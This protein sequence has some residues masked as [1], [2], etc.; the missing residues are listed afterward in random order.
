MP[1]GN[2]R[3]NWDKVLEATH[4]AVREYSRRELAPLSRKVIHYL[5]RVEASGFFGND[6][7]YKTLWDEYCHRI[8]EEPHG[9]LE[10]AWD[11]EISRTID[12]VIEIIPR[13]VAVL[14][15]VFAAWEL[16]AD[17]DPEFIGSV[18]PDGLRQVLRGEL[19]EGAARRRIG[20]LGPW[21]R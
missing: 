13:H 8:Q 6:Y 21:G 17:D 19:N 1:R 5:Q 3:K 15:T 9:Q 2:W 16:D 4:K 20:H 18:W 10:R 7:G 12:A 14:L 11:Y